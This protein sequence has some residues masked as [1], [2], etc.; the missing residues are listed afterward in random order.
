MSQIKHYIAAGKRYLIDKD[1]RFSVN[2]SLNLYKYM[3]DEKFIKR[4]FKIRM[5]YDLDL[6][7]PQT[8][9]E[10]LQWL[11]LYDRKPEYIQMVDK[12]EAKKYV[13][14]VIGE[15]Y[16]IPTLGVWERFEDIDFDALPKQFVLKCTHDS[17]GL[18]ICRDKSS[19]N[20]NEARKLINK[21]LKRNYFWNGREWPYKNVK[22]RIMAEKYMEDDFFNKKEFR[23]YK[24]FEFDG[25][26][27]A[28][29]LD[30]KF[31]DKSTEADYFDIKLNYLNISNVYPASYD[32][33]I[34]NEKLGKM[35]RLTEELL[36]VNPDLSVDFFEVNGCAYFG[37][38][39]FTQW[40]GIIPYSPESWDTT[41]GRWIKVP[42]EYGAGYTLISDGYVLLLHKKAPA[43]LI[44]YKFF[45]FSGTPRLLYISKGMENHST[46][47]ISFYGMDGKEKD[48]HRSDYKPYHN[49]VIPQNFNELR[50]KAQQLASSVD[51]PFT[52]IDMY[53]INNKVYFS[54]I[55][56]TPCGGFLPF[57]PKTADLE[58]GRY[59]K[60]PIEN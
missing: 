21:S 38:I 56:F 17:G 20:K 30:K 4:M 28:L 24:F 6:N 14:S 45:C 47:E 26:S 57:Y 13:T 31:N 10:K 48:F 40:T 32:L 33:Q 60:L 54:E 8:F 53:S 42:E 9:N 16:I 15:E 12:Y 43:G 35:K 52:R 58:L 29:Y 19:F 1:Y 2:H 55:T 36:K 18:V 59:I 44:D 11:K 46:A 51:C 23:N 22:P 49:A 50:D 7:N 41:L 5:G 34:K 25:V 27:K 3:S 37:E 39:T